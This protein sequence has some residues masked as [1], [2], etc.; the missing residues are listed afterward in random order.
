MYT[1]RDINW[2]CKRITWSSTIVLSTTL[3]CCCY[4][5]CAIFLWRIWHIVMHIPPCHHC[6]SCITLTELRFFQEGS[7]GVYSP[8]VPLLGGVSRFF[9]R[10][11]PAVLGFLHLV[12]LFFFFFFFFRY[13]CALFASSE[14]PAFRPKSL[15]FV[16][17]FVLDR[18]VGMKVTKMTKSIQKLSFW[19]TSRYWEIKSIMKWLWSNAVIEFPPLAWSFLPQS[20]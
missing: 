19:Y 3:F 20:A 11:I 13:F 17:V 4:A 10:N 6:P 1:E 5:K 12:L 15:N 9:V 16:L 8:T 18:L 2:T 7:E 14:C